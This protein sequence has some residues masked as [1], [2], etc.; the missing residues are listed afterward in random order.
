MLYREIYVVTAYIV[1]ANGTFN[2]LSGYPKTFDSKHYGNDLDKTRQR[3]YADWH[4]ALGAMGKV[5]TRE[6]QMASILRMSD[7][8]QVECARYGNLEPLPDPESDETT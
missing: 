6:L 7:G 5:D 4:D 1:D 2:A 3:A 8:M